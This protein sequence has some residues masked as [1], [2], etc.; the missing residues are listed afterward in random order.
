MKKVEL[1]L[2]SDAGTYLFFENSKRDKS[3]F[4]FL[5]DIVKPTINI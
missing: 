2:I 3:F 1:E 5:R 4:T